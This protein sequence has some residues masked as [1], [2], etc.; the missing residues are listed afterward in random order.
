MDS[1]V[2]EVEAVGTDSFQS[3]EQFRFCFGDESQYT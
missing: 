2:G 3:A 1:R